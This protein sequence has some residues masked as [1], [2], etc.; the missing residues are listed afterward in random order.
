M[1]KAIHPLALSLAALLL[2]VDTFVPKAVAAATERHDLQSQSRPPALRLDTGDEG[3]EG[4]PERSIEYFNQWIGEPLG[5]ERL[6]RMWE[7]VLATPS[8]EPP[9]S[10]DFVTSWELIGPLYSINAG[11]GNMTGRVRDIEASTTRVLAASGGLWRFHFGPVPMTETV[12][13]SWFGSFS[14]R[15][16]DPNTILLGTGEYGLGSGTGLYRTV[17][18][19]VN[20]TR[21]YMDPQPD[22]FHKVRWSPAGDVAYA[23]TPDGFYRSTDGGQLWTSTLIGNVTD[24]STVQGGSPNIVYAPVY[25]DGLYRSTDAGVTWSKMTAGGIPVSGTAEG[26]VDTPR[27]GWIYVSFTG[28]GVWRS[29]DDGAS[30]TNITPASDPNRFW[31]ANAIAA[32]PVEPNYVL[33]GGVGARLSTDAGLSWSPLVTPNLHADYHSF[34]WNSDGISVWAGNDGG[35]FHSLDHGQTWDSSSNVMPITQFYNIDCEKTEIGYMIGGTQD[36][37]LVYTPTQDLFWYDK[38]EGDGAGTC[39]DLYTLGRMWGI[40]GVF[41]GN[42]P[43]HRERTADGGASW[44]EVDN[45]IDANSGAGVIR[46]DNAFNPWL[47]TSAGRYVYDSTDG[48]NWTKSNPSPFPANVANVTSSTRVSPNSVAY[49]CMLYPVGGQS[50]FVR[51]GGVWVDRSAGLP[52][53]RPVHK[54]VPHPW[55]GNYADEAWALMNGINNP[56]QKIFHTTNRG[57]TW[58][59]VSGNLPDVPIGDLVVNPHDTNLLFVG[60]LLGCYRST[61]GGANWERWNNGLTPAVMV[62]EMAYIDLTPSG[63]PFYVVAATHGRSVWRRVGLGTDPASAGGTLPTAPL[64]LDMSTPNPVSSQATLRFFLSQ[65]G[66]ARMEVYDV[67]GERVST[68]LDATLSGGFHE[69][70][71][72]GRTLAPGVF[73]CRLESG[74]RTAVRKITVVH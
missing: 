74:G 2:V 10:E 21:A 8:E 9:G 64:R 46:G 16:S 29:T 49:A 38:G 4:G 31:Y 35:W 47:V 42:L 13:A 25:S 61:D 45:G 70:A 66:P 58:T 43:Y 20:W 33:L 71:V 51:D 24:L 39:V 44:Q 63:G 34:S 5:G 56:G 3:E 65:A 52:A 68:A 50:L 28:A 40:H 7:E 36:N 27:P 72:D 41:G 26:S 48:F 53:G 14:S 67:R 54:V 62:T 69:L 57:I 60:T 15:P 1:V 12:P 6:H 59:N 11:G 30:W 23:A 17:D 73:F 55:S 22:A 37:D 19:G 18:G 32:S